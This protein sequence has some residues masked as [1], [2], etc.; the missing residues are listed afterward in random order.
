MLGWLEE[1]LKEARKRVRKSPE[2]SEL[3]R[4][5][6]K[7]PHPLVGK[8]VL[9]IQCDGCMA[10]DHKLKRVGEI[11][12][13]KTHRE[14]WPDAHPHYKDGYHYAVCRVIQSREDLPEEL[15]YVCVEASNFQPTPSGKGFFWRH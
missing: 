12:D 2:Q 8:F 14:M 15:F 7:V 10:E 6:L 9:D 5:S 4:Q 11:I 13:V 1:S 3:I